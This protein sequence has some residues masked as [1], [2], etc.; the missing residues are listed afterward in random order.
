MRYRLAKSVAA[1]VLA[2]GALGGG[3]DQYF[4]MTQPLT[5]PVTVGIINKTP[6]RAI[7]TFGAWE[8]L[9]SQSLPQFINTRL[10]SKTNDPTGEGTASVQT[11]TLASGAAT[12]GCRRSISLG[13]SE[14]IQQINNKKDVLKIVSPPFEITNKGAMIT[15]V[16][17]SDAALDSPDVD[18]PTVGTAESVTVDNGVDYPCGSAVIFTLV[19]DAQAKGGFRVD[20]GTIY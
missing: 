20:V 12:P 8:P 10:E 17:F 4:Y 7:F 6:Y 18:N 15:G 11:L 13:S 14:L 5:N 16:N 2:V 9:D 3:C 1:A 19:Q